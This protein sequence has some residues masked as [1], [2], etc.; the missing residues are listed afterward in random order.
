MAAMWAGHIEPYIVFTERACN[1]VDVR[2]L[3]AY[4]RC[5]GPDWRV[6]TGGMQ[7]T[8][9]RDVRQ[10]TFADEPSHSRSLA[11]TAAY[12]SH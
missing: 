11:L 6:C 5:A 10:R 2:S 1:R 7:C 12:V 9:R 3:T 4:K 8:V